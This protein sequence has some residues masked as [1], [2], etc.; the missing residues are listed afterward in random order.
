MTILSLRTGCAG[1]DPGPGDSATDGESGFPFTGVTPTS[2][3]FGTVEIGVSSTA[4]VTV[5]NVGIA[6]LE[7]ADVV[8]TGDDASLTLDWAG[9]ISVLPGEG[10]NITVTWTPDVPQALAASL[11]ISSNDPIR[12]LIEV[13]IVGTTQFPV[14]DVTP[15][16]WDFGAIA[17][18]TTSVM[19]VNIANVGGI[20]LTVTAIEY[21][22]TDA[23]L[24]VDDATTPFVVAPGK[25]VDLRVTYHPTNDGPDDGALTVTSDDPGHPEVTVHQSGTTLPLPKCIVGE[26]LFSGDATD[27]SGHGN[28]GAAVNA[29]LTN[30]RNGSP[31]A[32]YSFDGSAY[33]DVPASESLDGIETN[34]A[35]TIAGW[36]YVETWSGEGSYSFPLFE[37]Y[38]SSHD[39]GWSVLVFGPGGVVA[40]LVSLY[41]SL[42]GISSAPFEFTDHQWYFVASTFDEG[43]REARIYVDGDL[44]GTIDSGNHLSST[45]SG[46][47]HI[48]LN[49][50]GIDE[51]AVGVVDDVYLFDCALS[52]SEIAD[53]YLR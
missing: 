30:D 2:V 40:D 35:V 3:D 32:A 1:Q 53:L 42:Y 16:E 26:W 28:D 36:M 50:A 20:D 10:R 37:R 12:P 13:P 31:N 27:S 5:A 9:P 11:E 17:R 34:G 38:R 48:G 23:D 41:T 29:V 7:V 44:I 51:Y 33:I 39:D 22:A 43:S 4:T 47:I 19:G 18:G 15:P 24:S 46:D 49:A 52:D 45:D 14:I 25:S 8:T 6:D 21:E